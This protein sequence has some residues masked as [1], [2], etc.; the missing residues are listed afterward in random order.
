MRRATGFAA[1]THAFPPQ[2]LATVRPVYKPS[3]VTVY[4][5]RSCV[6]ER[7]SAFLFPP[8]FTPDFF[9]LNGYVEQ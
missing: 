4:R 8:I 5:Q 3:V 6:Q 7:L 1:F 9:T 2:A